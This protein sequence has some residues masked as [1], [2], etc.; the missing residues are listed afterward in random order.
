MQ[1]IRKKKQ[2]LRNNQKIHK[3]KSKTTKPKKNNRKIK[4]STT[5]KNQNFQKT[6]NPKIQRIPKNPKNKKKTRKTRTSRATSPSSPVVVEHVLKRNFGETV[7]KTQLFAKTQIR[8]T[9]DTFQT[10]VR[11]FDKFV[12]T[13]TNLFKYLTMCLPFYNF[14]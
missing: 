8:K 6:K 7:G 3:F 10:T 14:C 1:T 12:K 4:K 13:L 5:F 2:K 11:H 9:F